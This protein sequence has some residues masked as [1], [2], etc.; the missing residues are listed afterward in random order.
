MGGDSGRTRLRSL[1]ADADDLAFETF[2]AQCLLAPT[3][4]APRED[5]P[6]QKQMAQAAQVIGANK[7]EVHILDYAAGRGRLAV[8]LRE[9]G[10]ANSRKFTYFAYQAEAYTTDEERR[11]CLS[12]IQELGQPQPAEAYLVNRLDRLCVPGKRR[13]DLVVMCNVLH[14]IPVRK[15]L[16]C[17]QQVHDVLADDGQLVILEDQ[18]LP[19]GELPHANGYIVLDDVA[20]MSLFNSGDAIQFCSAERNGRLTAYGIPRKYLPGATTAS[21]I[22]AL[23]KVRNMAKEELLR[24]REGGPEQRSFQAGRRHAHYALLHTNAQLALNEYGVP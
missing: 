12:R 9:A 3:V 21:I 8:S 22:D 19:V 18:L 11:E 17:F 24:L 23:K 4:A 7:E 6:Q 20:L 13:M 1:L 5:D 14:E 16:E 2:A 15:W 10:L